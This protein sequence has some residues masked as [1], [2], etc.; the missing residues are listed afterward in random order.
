MSIELHALF[1]FPG[2]CRSGLLLCWIGELQALFSG[3][4]AGLNLRVVRGKSLAFEKLCLARTDRLA[5]MIRGRLL[6]RAHAHVPHFSSTVVSATAR[7][8]HSNSTGTSEQ[9]DRVRSQ[10]KN[11]VAPTSTAVA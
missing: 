3:A 11:T 6:H 4:L 10:V 2:R 9:R 5:L 7:R 8:A 1:R